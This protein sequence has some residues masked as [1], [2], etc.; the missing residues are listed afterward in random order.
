M[1]RRAVTLDI[2][3]GGLL[4]SRCGFLP[5]GAVVWVCIRLPDRPEALA[6]QARVVRYEVVGVPRYGLKLLCL[7][8]ADR[9][10]LADVSG[11]TRGSDPRDLQ[12]V[13][14]GR[15]LAQTPPN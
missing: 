11:A 1:M 5:A 12:R 8:Q 7:G 2:G 15:R 10:R 13:E 3:E 6:C 14:S 4:V 9:D